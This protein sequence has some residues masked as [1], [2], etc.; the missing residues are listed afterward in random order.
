M[1]GPNYYLNLIAEAAAQ[2]AGDKIDVT[3]AVDTSALAAGDLA[4]DS[5]EVPLAVTA[6]HISMLQDI[7]VIDKSDTGP[8]LTLFFTTETVDFGTLNAAPSISD[9]D[10]AKILGYVVLAAADWVDMGGAK[11]ISAKNIGLTIEG[12]SD[13]TSV[14]MAGIITAGGTGGTF[15]ASDL[16][17]RLGV[18]KG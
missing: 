7:L 15:G 17:F 1:S 9:A 14:Y 10:A 5:T 13:A 11:I 3:P 16:V 2:S 18:L 8:S 6:N 12:A 4:F